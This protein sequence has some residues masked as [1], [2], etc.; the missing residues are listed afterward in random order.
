M[1]RY[2][3][4]HIVAPW[5]SFPPFRASFIFYSQL[6]AFRHMTIGW[7]RWCPLTNGSQCLAYW[8]PLPKKPPCLSFEVRLKAIRSCHKQL[9]LQ[10]GHISTAMKAFGPGYIREGSFRGSRL[11]LIKILG[12]SSLR[13]WPVLALDPRQSGETCNMICALT[14][15]IEDRTANRLYLFAIV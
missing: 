7:D 1:A 12:P 9:V 10:T 5:S 3:G 4:S 15:M 13:L 2:C 6:P 8:R 11:G 14:E